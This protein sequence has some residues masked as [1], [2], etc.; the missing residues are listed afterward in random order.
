MSGHGADVWLSA[1]N[2]ARLL[3]NGFNPIPVHN[4]S[5]HPAIKDWR[6]FCWDQPDDGDIAAWARDHAGS[7]IGCACG[8]SVAAVD[9]DCGDEARTRQVI[10]Q[11]RSHLGPTPLIRYGRPD[12]VALIYRCAEPVLSAGFG[13]VDVLGLGAQFVA[14]GLHPRTRKP[15]VW[16]DEAGPLNT[17]CNSLPA[18]DNQQVETFLGSVVELWDQTNEKAGRLQ[19]DNISLLAPLSS[20]TVLFRMLVTRA[21]HGRNYT[22][23]KARA[24]IDKKYYD[25]GSGLKVQWTKDAASAKK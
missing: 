2:L 23:R 21:F 11:A 14:Y 22:Y 7:S 4:V 3:E 15:Y 24:I 1:Q 17:P 13:E 10:A 6:R 9:I 25:T 12:R 18:I 19:I 20:T 8:H 16:E 5:K